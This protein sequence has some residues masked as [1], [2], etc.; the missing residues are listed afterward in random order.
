MLDVDGLISKISGEQ[1]KGSWKIQKKVIY[2]HS[3]WQILQ[4][5]SNKSVSLLSKQI[6][7]YTSSPSSFTTNY[8]V[9]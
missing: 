2:S 7:L 1:S 5:Y 3:K 6:T 9:I 4:F 8:K